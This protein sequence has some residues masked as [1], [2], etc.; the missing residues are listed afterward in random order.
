MAFVPAPNVIQVEVRALHDGQKIENRFTIDVLA[1]VTPG[2]VVAAADLVSAWAAGTYFPLLPSPV[3]LTETFAKDLTTAEG[4]QHS[5]SPGS[6]VAG[7]NGTP[8]CPNE[9]SLCISLRTA[10][11]GRSARGRAY[12][13]AL[14]R[15]L[16]DGN[17]IN[18]TLKTQLVAAFESLRVSIADA[19]WLWIVT[20]YVTG[21]APRG[22]GPVYFPITSVVAVD[23]IVDSQRRR[24]P[25]N[26]S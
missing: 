20:S 19:G 25:G 13:L 14:T 1:A 12:V 22:G 23:D 15:A 18:S 11:S 17:H 26:G 4:S 8:S 5:V 3:T 10:S 7:G 24:K 16:V 21:G 6:V 9:V 2:D